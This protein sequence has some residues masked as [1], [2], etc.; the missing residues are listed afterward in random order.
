LSIGSLRSAVAFLTV[1]PVAGG[2]KKPAARLGRAYFPAVGA[3]LGLIAGLVF[4]LAASLTTQLVG[5]VAAVAVLAVLTGGLHLD[6]L[7]DAADGLF[8]RGTR[9]QR[10]DIMRDPRIGSFGAIALIVVLLGDAAALSALAPATAIVALVIAGALSRWAMLGVIAF[11]PYVRETGLG[12]AAGG[13]SRTFDLVLGSALAAVACMLDWK[14]AAIAVLAVGLG[15]LVVSVLARR[16]IGGATGD[17]Y[18]AATE[19]CQLAALVSFAV[20]V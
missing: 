7:A 4:G 2:E 17:V 6:G 15:A 5:A 1:I 13:P 11:V 10:L 14:H 19:L 9:A 20:H 3:L 16:L 12:V 8:G 18:G